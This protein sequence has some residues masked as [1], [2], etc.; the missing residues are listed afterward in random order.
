MAATT[1]F[2]STISLIPGRYHARLGP[3][4]CECCRTGEVLWVEEK[5]DPRDAR[6]LLTEFANLVVPRGQPRARAAG[7]PRPLRPAGKVGGPPCQ[8]RIRARL[9]E[10]H[11]PTNVT[12]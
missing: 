5:I 7:A 4:N 9:K 11:I 2:V 12:G 6:R 10:P 1:T 8:P 3:A